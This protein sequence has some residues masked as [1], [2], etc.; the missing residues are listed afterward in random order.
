VA[1]LGYG[2]PSR[3]HAY[4]PFEDTKSER[5]SKLVRAAL[6]AKATNLLL[7]VLF[8]S[9]LCNCCQ[10]RDWTFRDADQFLFPPVL[11]CT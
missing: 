5:T 7:K 11:K 6:T 2:L 3:R 4:L 8:S 1:V 9:V 10:R